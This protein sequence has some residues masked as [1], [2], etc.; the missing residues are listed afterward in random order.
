VSAKAENLGAGQCDLYRRSGLVIMTLV[1]CGSFLV[2]LGP[3]REP[4]VELQRSQI[5]WQ[6][7][8]K[9]VGNWEEKTKT[10]WNLSSCRRVSAV[11]PRR[12]HIIATSMAILF[13]LPPKSTDP[14]ELTPLYSASTSN[15]DTAFL[16][17]Y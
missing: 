11:L 12:Q 3:R 14:T 6:E 4:S 7:E 13:L 9:E 10:A 8:Q 1:N 2:R 16:Y 15:V 5:T 17:P